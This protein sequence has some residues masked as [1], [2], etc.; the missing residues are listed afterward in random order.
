MVDF[1]VSYPSYSR[2]PGRRGDALF[3]QNYALG[4]QFRVLAAR[5]R[6]VAMDS[7]ERS[8]IPMEPAVYEGINGVLM[9]SAERS[10]IPIEPAVNKGINGVAMDSAER[11]QIPRWGLAR[12]LVEKTNSVVHSWACRAQFQLEATGTPRL[13]GGSGRAPRRKK[14]IP[15]QVYRPCRSGLE[16]DSS[17]HLISA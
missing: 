2:R 11:S 15:D 16:K 3:V 8:Q 10:Q 7:A 14:R 13:Q 9:N 5:R 4:A 12:C 6:R 17:G 1:C